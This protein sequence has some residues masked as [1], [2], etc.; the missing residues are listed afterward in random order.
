[1]ARQILKPDDL[2]PILA[3]AEQWIRKCLIEDRSVF[4]PDSRWTNKS[5]AHLVTTRMSA[6]LNSEELR[7][8][9]TGGTNSRAMVQRRIEF[10]RDKFLGV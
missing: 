5:S 2:S 8:L 9:T 3:S 4:L 7:Q 6:W 10:C 1:M